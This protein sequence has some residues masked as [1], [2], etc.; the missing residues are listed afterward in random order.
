MF[1]LILLQDF[2][3]SVGGKYHLTC[4]HYVQYR[5][6]TGNMKYTCCKPVKVQGYLSEKPAGLMKCVKG[7]RLSGHGQAGSIQ[8]NTLYFKR[9]AHTFIKDQQNESS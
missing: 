8:T 7:T 3:I 2:W 4:F 6:S 9:R 5:G 1:L